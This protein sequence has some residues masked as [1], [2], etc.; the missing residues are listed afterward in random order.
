MALTYVAELIVQQCVIGGTGC[1]G[2]MLVGGRRVL[3]LM[4]GYYN[5]VGVNGGRLWIEKQK[6]ENGTVY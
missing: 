3:E 2:R 6:E 4:V 1:G 5:S